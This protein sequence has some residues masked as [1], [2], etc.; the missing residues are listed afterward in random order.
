M[1]SFETNS[2]GLPPVFVIIPAGNEPDGALTGPSGDS[3]PPVCRGLPRGLDSQLLTV[4]I[5]LSL[6]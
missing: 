3:M 6:L 1:T 4:G 2:C 5:R